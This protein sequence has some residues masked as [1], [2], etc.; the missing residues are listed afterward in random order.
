MSTL[1]AFRLEERTTILLFTPSSSNDR[2][3][4]GTWRSGAGT[5]G[6]SLVIVD[7][8]ANTLAFAETQNNWLTLP[9][10]SASISMSSVVSGQQYLLKV[11]KE[12]KT[13]TASVVNIKDGSVLATLTTT[14]EQG[15]NNDAGHFNGSP[16]IYNFSGTCKFH[17][18]R[19]VS[20]IG[21]PEIFQF[22]D[23]V[24][25]MPNYSVTYSERWNI[26]L[27]GSLKGKM[28]IGGVA[29]SFGG[30]DISGI[31][32]NT[33]PNLGMKNIF[34]YFGLNDQDSG[35]ID[36]VSAV[37]SLVSYCETNK[38]GLI[39]GILPPVTGRTYTN[40]NS[41]LLGLPFWVKKVRFDLALSDNNDGV[42]PAFSLHPNAT[43]M[44]LMYERVKIDVPELFT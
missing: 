38:I 7:G 42:T 8:S 25:E 33:I 39:V 31:L 15:S 26:L 10:D 36:F 9:T 29:S 11:V 27:R 23:S 5:K 34:S 24:S 18:V 2:F 16:I 30:Q 3:A 43:G 19:V 4:F 17:G 20:T 13:L 28:C 44:N 40:L 1:N 32:S 12:W 14:G 6:P 22:G 41:Y 37:D 21:N 35:E